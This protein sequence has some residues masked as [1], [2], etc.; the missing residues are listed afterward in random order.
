MML[1]GS[2]SAALIV[3]RDVP[4]FN[5]IIALGVLALM[6]IIISI[7]TLSNFLKGFIG[8]HPDIL[9]RNGHIVKE[10]MIKNQINVEQLLSG[11]RNKGYRRLHDVEFAILEPNGQLSVIPKSLG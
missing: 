4:L 5:A 10:N 2:A 6:H 11:L 7:S 8:G 9:I 1:I 3:N